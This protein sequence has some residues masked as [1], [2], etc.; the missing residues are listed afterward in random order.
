MK[1]SQVKV[2]IRPKLTDSFGED[3]RVDTQRGFVEI[4]RAIN[5]CNRDKTGYLSYVL[6]PFNC[7]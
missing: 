1:D 5:H 3:F 2:R 7:I 6:T 4:L